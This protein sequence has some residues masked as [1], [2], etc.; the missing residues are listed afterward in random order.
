MKKIILLITAL[1]VSIP[2]MAETKMKNELTD[3][4]TDKIKNIKEEDKG[5][6]IQF[7]RH[8]ALYKMAKTNPRY[9]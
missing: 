2:S 9:E 7:T 6:V 8:A 4:F 3:S 5:I 1:V